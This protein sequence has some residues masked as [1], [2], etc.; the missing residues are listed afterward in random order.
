MKWT[1]LHPKH[2]F[3]CTH[4]RREVVNWRA[5]ATHLL[6]QTALQEN[7]VALPHHDNQAAWR[8]W[9]R[10]TIIHADVAKTHSNRSPTW[11]RIITP[12]SPVK[13]SPF[14]M[15]LASATM[16]GFVAVHAPYIRGILL[17]QQRRHAPKPPGD[18]SAPPIVVLA[19][20]PTRH[21]I[22][23]LLVVSSQRVAYVDGT[24][25]VLCARPADQPWSTGWTTR[26]VELSL[27]DLGEGVREG[28]PRPMAVHDETV[29]VAE[30]GMLMMVGGGGGGLCA[31]VLSV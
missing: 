26:R 13:P 24:C 23:G 18:P 17:L 30:Y 29:V 1:I 4:P 25:L 27:R 6:E 21:R 11:M 14:N 31:G 7:V 10:D 3:P 15:T 2:I 12:S 22:T 19:M 28:M 16:Q 20:L 9:F 5:A 8:A